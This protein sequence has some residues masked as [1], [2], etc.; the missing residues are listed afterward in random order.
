MTRRL[1]DCAFV[2]SLFLCSATGWLW[3]R[4]QSTC[5][6]IQW[7]SDLHEKDP[8]GIGLSRAISYAAYTTPSRFTVDRWH[9]LIKVGPELKVTRTIS[10]KGE[11]H[12]KNGSRHL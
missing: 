10:E 11:A 5:E 9:G 1:L 3:F 2:A 4:S 7:I 8:D 6:W 12:D